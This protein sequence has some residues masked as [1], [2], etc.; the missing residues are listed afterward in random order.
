[1]CVMA[2]VRRRSGGCGAFM[3]A[4]EIFQLKEQLER[5]GTRMSLEGYEWIIEDGPQIELDLRKEGIG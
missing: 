1:M 2:I 3:D 4:E 5:K